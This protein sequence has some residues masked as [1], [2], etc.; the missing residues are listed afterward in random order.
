VVFRLRAHR[1]QA[2]GALLY[3]RHGIVRPMGSSSPAFTVRPLEPRD[4]RGAADLYAPYVVETTI[5]FELDPP[6]E[7]EMARRF[8]KLAASGHPAFV[9]EEEGN[10]L[11]YAYAGPFRARP[12]YA[13][14]V[15]HSVYVRRELRRSGVGRVLMMALLEAC[16]ARGFKEMVAVIS[17]S[18][19]S[20]SIPFH[21]RLGFQI[22]GRLERVGE[23]FGRELGITFMQRSTRP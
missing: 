16:H 12:A 18:E 20:G 17:D 6:S 13:K 7:E 19:T 21:E 4:A 22:V 5:S 23:K 8:A 9:A 1:S 3:P 14:T 15:E 2:P 10:L 11:G